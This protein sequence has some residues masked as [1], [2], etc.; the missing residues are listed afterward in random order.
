M[1]KLFSAILCLA[2]LLS[3]CACTAETSELPGTAPKN[4]PAATIGADT[5][6]AQSV[7]VDELP[8]MESYVYSSETGAGLYVCYIYLHSQSGLCYVDKDGEHRECAFSRDEA[9]NIAITLND[10]VWNFRRVD[11][12]LELSGG[13]PLTAYM[14]ENADN[15][16]QI[17][18]GSL[19]APM[20]SLV[21]RSGVY[22]MDISGYTPFGEA[23]QLAIDLTNMV[24]TLR[25]Y[26]GS[27]YEG[28][29][30]FTQDILRCIFPEGSVDFSVTGGEELRLSAR[31][32]LPFLAYPSAGYS[33]RFGFVFDESAALR[34]SSASVLRDSRRLYCESFRFY[35]EGFSLNIEHNALAGTWRFS[36]NGEYGDV[37]AVSDEGDSIILTD[38][39]NTWSFRR[40]GN[41]L[42]YEGSLL[43]AYGPGAEGEEPPSV[44]VMHGTVF[45]RISASYIYHMLPYVMD[46]SATETKSDISGQA[47]QVSLLLDTEHRRFVLVDQFGT[48]Q[49]GVLEYDGRWLRLHYGQSECLVRPEAH[50]LVFRAYEFFSPMYVD[51]NSELHFNPLYDAQAAEG[52]EFFIDYAPAALPEG[53][54]LLA[55]EYA[56]YTEEDGIMY[57][58][59]IALIPE[60]K[61]FYIG[62]YDTDYGSYTE[63]DGTL[64]MLSAESGHEYIFS[65]QGESL[66]QTGGAP[67]CLYGS[68]F[69]GAWGIK[70]E[71]PSGIKFP[72]YA[73]NAIRSGSYQL[74]SELCTASI[75]LDL[76]AMTCTIVTTDGTEHTGPIQIRENRVRMEIPEGA[77]Y[78]SASSV[79]GIRISNLIEALKIAPELEDSDL[80]FKYVE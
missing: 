37:W 17:S 61:L 71:L 11:T 57:D 69:Q 28:S 19:F 24:C 67:V 40:Q 65:R 29:I 9:G 60:E 63:Q 22:G 20:E 54:R 74:E 26:D 68:I 58:S 46:I 80:Y 6:S 49:Q 78:F 72:L 53:S 45:P 51:V 25:G 44:T 62:S 34:D 59:V 32:T 64:R 8:I 38:G 30:V 79:D 3:L 1:K 5:V 7:T 36:S 56:I 75:R 23:P 48:A 76:E 33:G 42:V 47:S 31:D 4:D 2:V 15:M 70:V 43:L 14:P 12:G 13:T 73:R 39:Q 50:G 77:F 66:V 52:L 35:S 55:E 10:S 16:V 41:D 18:S 21:I 27:L